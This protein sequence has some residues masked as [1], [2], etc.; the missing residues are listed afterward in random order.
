MS[1]AL[2]ASVAVKYGV[3]WVLALFAAR[4][5]PDD[6]KLRTNQEINHLWWGFFVFLVDIVRMRFI[7]RW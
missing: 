5:A 3:S 4:G 1:E 2:L 6:L 7:N